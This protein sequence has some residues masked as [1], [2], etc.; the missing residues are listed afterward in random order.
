MHSSVSPDRYRVIVNHGTCYIFW[1]LSPTAFRHPFPKCIFVKCIFA[2]CTLLS[3]AGLFWSIEGEEE[4]TRRGWELHS[5]RLTAF[6]CMFLFLAAIS[7]CF[8]FH[9]LYRISSFSLKLKCICIFEEGADRY[10]QTSFN[11]FCDIHNC[12]NMGSLQ[13][14]GRSF[15][16]GPKPNPN[17]K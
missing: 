8:L 2:K 5:K 10:G 4:G 15:D 6:F 14:T 7:S 16:F 9:I 17:L 11:F 13:E 12:G 1:K 3:F